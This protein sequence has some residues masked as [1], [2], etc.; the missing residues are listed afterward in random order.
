MEIAGNVNSRRLP[1]AG[2]VAVVKSTKQNDSQEYFIGD[3]E[4]PEEQ[5]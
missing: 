3:K 2:I 1:L 5:E 4:M